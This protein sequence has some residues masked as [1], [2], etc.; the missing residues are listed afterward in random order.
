MVP[1]NL[2]TETRLTLV[3]RVLRESNITKSTFLKADYIF[4][5]HIA[6]D[7]HYVLMGFAPKQ[8]FVFVIDSV[9]T[10]YVYPI[11][12]LYAILFNMLPGDAPVGRKK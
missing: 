7:A 1:S 3:A 10:S 12:T 5:P 11:D 9:N 6:S 8:Q 2:S 4:I